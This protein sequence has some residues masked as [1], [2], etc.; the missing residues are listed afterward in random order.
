MSNE[1]I[2]KYD[3]FKIENFGSFLIIFY[4]TSFFFK[5]QFR[6]RRLSFCIICNCQSKSILEQKYS[7]VLSVVPYNSENL[8]F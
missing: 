8:P 7:P 4:E 5:Y 3:L 1:R 2:N 6:V